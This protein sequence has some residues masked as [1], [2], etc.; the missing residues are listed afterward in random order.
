M[1]ETARQVEVT[2]NSRCSLVKLKLNTSK[3]LQVEGSRSRDE[4]EV[5]DMLPEG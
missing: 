2:G 5:G 3:N 4:G 1:F